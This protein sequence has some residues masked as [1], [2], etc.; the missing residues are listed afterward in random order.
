[1]PPTKYTP[2]LQEHF[3]TLVENWNPF[4]YRGKGK[5]ASFKKTMY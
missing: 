4:R 1:M 3:R 5:D 2:E